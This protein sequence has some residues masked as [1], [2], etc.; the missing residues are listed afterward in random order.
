MSDMMTIYK[1]LSLGLSYP[2]K[3]NWTVLEFM[4]E[5]S[6]GLTVGRTGETAAALKKYLSERKPVIRDIQHEYL[7]IFDTEVKVSPYET[8]YLTEKLSRKPFELADI[9]GFYHAFGFDVNEDAA[10]KEPVDHMAVELEFMAILAFKEAYAEELRQE[11]NRM[12]VLEAKTKFLKE[13]LLRWGFAY[14]SRLGELASS[15]FYKI[16][17]NILESILELECERCGLDDALYK[18][19][20]ARVS[21]SGV[22]EEELTC[23]QLL[24]DN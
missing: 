8:E 9:A 22:G 16:L 19:D 13:H 14:C 17:G 20:R 5:E 4:L 2:E 21:Y 24:Q 12:I 15:P 23:G 1:L 7:D 11:E 10:N 18:N 6:S 3:R